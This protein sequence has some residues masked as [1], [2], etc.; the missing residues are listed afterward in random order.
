MATGFLK[1]GGRS[2]TNDR[3]SHQYVVENAADEGDVL[4]FVGSLPDTI[5]GMPFSDFTAEESEDIDGM[6]DL[7]V[8][9]GTSQNQNQSQAINTVEYQ[10]SFQA[11]SAHIYQSLETIASYRDT[12]AYPNAAPNFHGAINVIQDG[13]TNRVEGIQLPTPAETFKLTY[14]VNNDAVSGEYQLLVQNLCG[15]VNSQTFRGLPAGSLMLVRC[16]GGRS[17]SGVWTVT[18]GFG[19]SPNKTNISVGNFVVAAKDGWDL[20]WALYRTGKDTTANASVKKPVAAYVE[21][22]YERDDFNTLGLPA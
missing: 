2:L 14:V 1:A 10:F 11:P 21:R 9:W 6:F 17:S 13:G 8:N 7:T 3:I 19:Y 18:Y 16:D 22:V 12:T 15:K 20:L 5:G 4:T